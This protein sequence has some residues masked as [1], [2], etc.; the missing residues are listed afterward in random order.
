MNFEVKQLEDD[1]VAVWLVDDPSFVG[2]VSSWHLVEPK[3]NQLRQAYEHRA[4]CQDQGC[5]GGCRE[6]QQSYL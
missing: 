2:W 5:P 4:R 1:S 3:A 6:D